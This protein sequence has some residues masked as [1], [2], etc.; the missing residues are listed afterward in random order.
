MEKETLKKFIIEN[1]FDK[2]NKFNNR[3]THYSWWVNR[4]Y[5]QQY[6][7]IIQ[8]TDHLIDATLT[9]RV[10]DIM[11]DI[12]KIQYCVVCET[13]PKLFIG[14]KNGYRNICSVKCS[15]R[16]EETNLKRQKTKLERYGDPF[17]KDVSKTKQTNIEKYGFEWFTQSDE[18]KNKAK[19]TKLEKYGDSNFSNLE[20]NKRTCLQRYGV[21]YV[22]QVPE[23]VD[24]IQ[25]K[26]GN[27]LPVLRNKE[28]LINENKTKSIVQIANELGVTYRA[29][30]LWYQKFDIDIIYH[31]TNYSNLQK[32]IYDYVSTIADN[33][34]INNRN[35]IFPKELDI[36]VEDKNF[37]IELNGC[38]WH[39]EDPKRHIEK[40]IL[41]QNKNIKLIQFW[42]IEWIHKKEIC[43]SIIKTNLGVNDVV[44]ARKCVVN[45]VDDLS[46]KNFLETNHIQGYVPAKIVKGLYYND[47]LVAL[48][49]FGK[50]RFNKNYEWELLRYCNKL[51]TNVVGGFS[52]LFK[53]CDLN[54]IISYS[55]K[56]LFTGD[57]YKNNKFLYLNDSPPNFF[58]YKGGATLSRMNCRR[59]NINKILKEYDETKSV[60]ANM[61]RE[62]W[63]KVY[64]CGNSVWVYNKEV[65]NGN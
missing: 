42:D 24:K 63:L 45:D 31:Q 51:G 38:Y 43:K 29:V 46:Y 9:Q 59:Y 21:E 40:T 11:N 58:F 37:A 36:F 1:L 32:E 28:W 57:I 33:I 53:Q 55:D 41:C 22:T 16:S 4:N 65:N 34:S 13:H 10:Y 49:S 25:N 60:H 14:Y 62:G 56:R 52:K 39:A 12:E 30:Y 27:R 54:N 8:Y 15:L 50:P 35:I 48:I 44:Y 6:N 47:E 5:V 23:I 2:N 20:K 18:F 3:I 19:N 64:D 17:Y 7:A 26:K 61:N